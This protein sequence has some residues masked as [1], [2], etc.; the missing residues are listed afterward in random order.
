MHYEETLKRLKS[1]SDPGA[2]MAQFGI[3]PKETYG[4]SIPNLRKMV[5]KMGRS[6]LL[7]QQLW[8][9]GVHEAA[10]FA[11]TVGDRKVVTRSKQRIR[12]KILTRGAFAMNVTAISSKRANLLIKKLLNRVPEKKN[13]SKERGSYSWLVQLLV[14]RKRMINNVRSSFL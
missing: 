14:T 2:A 8:A 4:V 5:N 7:A 6:H 3:N 9:S 10:T 12:H 13:S 1:L 11:S